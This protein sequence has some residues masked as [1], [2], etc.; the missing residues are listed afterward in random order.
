MYLIR[1]VKTMQ[2][3]KSLK[4]GPSVISIFTYS[5]ACLL[6]VLPPQA[7]AC[8]SGTRVEL[9]ITPSRVELNYDDATH[10][11][12]WDSQF[13]MTEYDDLI[14]FLPANAKVEIQN[15]N[16]ETVLKRAESDNEPDPETMN[17]LRLAPPEAPNR[18]IW[19]IDA[20]NKGSSTINITVGNEKKTLKVSVNHYERKYFYMETGRG[21]YTLDQKVTSYEHPFSMLQN[22]QVEIV[23]PGKV[24]DNWRLSAFSGGDFSISKVE[25]VASNDDDASPQVTVTLSSAYV[26]Q[27]GKP[28][29]VVIKKGRFLMGK[30]FNFYFEVDPAPLC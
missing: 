2:I 30:S 27:R 4:N 3:Q 5:F 8:I 10:M 16:D 26:S 9:P 17:V 24:D 19:E 14:L 1:R 20:K 13:S 21:V 11:D 7:F 22:R 18:T 29:S 15:D 12:K 23:L 6:T 28:F 25:P